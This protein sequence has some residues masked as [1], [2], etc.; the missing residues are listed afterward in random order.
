MASLTAALWRGILHR[1]VMFVA[2]TVTVAACAAPKPST[3]APY[4]A[5]VMDART[6]E[7][8]YSKNSE[9]RLHPASLTK[10]MTLYIAFQAIESGEIGLD[11]MVTITRNAAAEPPSKLGLKAGQKVAL[12]HLIRAAA[13]KSANDAATAIGEGIGGSEA[14]FAERMN[15]TAKALGMTGSTFRNANGLTTD[16]HMST[17]RDMT[18]LGRRLFY[19]FPQ[20]YNIFSRRET[21]AGLADVLN[22]NRRFLEAYKG[23]DGIKTGFTN[24]AGFNLTASAERGG[25]RIIASVFGGTS[26][27]QRNSKMAE[28]LDL[29]FAKAPAN[30]PVLRPQAI[31]PEVAPQPELVAKGGDPLM[32]AKTIRVVTAVSKTLRPQRRPGDPVPEVVVAAAPEPAPAPA[33]DT[34][35]DPLAE[36]IAAEV[37]VAAM[38]DGISGA[39]AEA[40]GGPAAP[41]PATAPEPVPFEVRTAAVAEPEPLPEPEPVILHTA[42]TDGQAELAE[43]EAAAPE[44]VTRISTSGGRAWGVSIGRFPSSDAAGRALMKVMLIESATLGQGSRKVVSRSSGHDANFFGLTEEQADLAC[45][46]LQA[47]GMECFTIGPGA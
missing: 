42:S 16:G 6:G 1:M 37:A 15:R 18:I 10:M 8:L 4:A 21:D 30:A 12:R 25:V 28:L 31:Q 33:V 24:A 35:D 45:R 19:D 3:A 22:T 20:Y 32:P 39:L 27:A 29:G 46:R 13:I 5:F 47:R 40:L 9:A 7:T 41:V 44:T 17:A 11:S 2:V 34:F 36:A 43:A 26:V 23:A 14:A 38:Q